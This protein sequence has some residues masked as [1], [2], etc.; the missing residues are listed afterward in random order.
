MPH[1]RPV[2]LQYLWS[3]KHMRCG[4]GFGILIYTVHGIYCKRLKRV[5]AWAPAEIFPEGGGKTTNTLGYFVGRQ[6]MTSLF[7]F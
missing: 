2:G 3:H 1:Q 6:N 5:T 4:T 7:T